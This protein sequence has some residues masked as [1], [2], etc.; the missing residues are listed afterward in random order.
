MTAKVRNL[1]ALGGHVHSI[2]SYLRDA[3]QAAFFPRRDRDREC[4][5]K[6]PRRPPDDNVS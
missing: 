1:H 3:G 2:Q 6:L 4:A 5:G